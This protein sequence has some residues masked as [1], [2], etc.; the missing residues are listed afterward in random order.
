VTRLVLDTSAYSHFKR[1]DEAVV[2]IVTTAEW[3]G[4]PAIVLGEL[5]AGF[6][7][8]TRVEANERE[9]SAFL[10][11]R[12][13]HVLDVDDDAAAFYADIVAA[14]LAAGTPLPTNDI[15]IAAVAAREGAVVVTYDAHFRAIARVGSRILTR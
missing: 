11:H 1:N 12:V 9:L 6:R 4:V 10:G 15:W 13:V 8:G 2:S 3:I 5:R 7:R 14:L